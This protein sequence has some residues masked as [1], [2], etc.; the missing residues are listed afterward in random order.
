MTRSTNSSSSLAAIADAIEQQP[1]LDAL[2]DRI[3]PVA[4][5]LAESP[6]SSVLRGEWLGHAAHPM[7]TDL[8]LGCFTSATI[9]D[10]LVGRRGAPAA[11]RLIGIGLLALP[12]TIATG[13]VDWHEAADDPRIRRAGVVHAAGNLVAGML[14]LSSYR[15][16]RAGHRLR[17]I[18]LALGGGAVA[19]GSGYLGGHMSFA[20]ASGQGEREPSSSDGDRVIDVTEPV[21]NP[22]EAP[23]AD[24][25][26]DPASAS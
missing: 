19:A 21:A 15:Q 20:R 11:R 9:V 17:G 26:L 14:Y 16:R 23:I 13:L 25:L 4:R 22:P 10:L 24:Q 5:L 8:P 18:A 6:V 2:A 7:L 12:P 1:G 3:E